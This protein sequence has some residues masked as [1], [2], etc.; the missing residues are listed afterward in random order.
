MRTPAKNSGPARLNMHAIA[1]ALQSLQPG[2]AVDSTGSGDY[3]PL[4]EDVIRRLIAGYF[5]VDQLLQDDVDLFSFGASHHWLE[6]NHIVLCGTSPE[7][8]LQAADHICLTE[9]HFYNDAVGG[10]GE[11]MEWAGLHRWRGTDSFAATLF[12]HTI[13]T[14]QLFIEGNSRT[15]TLIASYILAR[16]G[17]PPLV[18]TDA[19]YSDYKALVHDCRRLV[20]TRWWDMLVFPMRCYRV[21]NFIRGA[22]NK[23]FLC[24]N[25]LSDADEYLERH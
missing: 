23:E 25:S 18:V 14:P 6:L 2:P 22:A 9:R 10:I 5:Y 21:E 24:G 7:T 17:Y 20:R 13:S 1:T 11:R 12:L 19:T 16:S 3:E 8:R 15:A 4:T